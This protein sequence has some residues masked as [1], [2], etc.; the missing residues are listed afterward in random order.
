MNAVSVDIRDNMVHIVKIYDIAV[1]TAKK[2][3]LRKPFYKIRY[4]IGIIDDVIVVVKDQTAVLSFYVAEF[5][6]IDFMGFFF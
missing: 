1:I 3:L 4:F 6:Q 2:G 5:G